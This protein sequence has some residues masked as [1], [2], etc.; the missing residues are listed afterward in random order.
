MGEKMIL[1]SIT[2][3][4]VIQ[5]DPRDMPAR[6][7]PPNAPERDAIHPKP[8]Y[9]RR[10]RHPN[11]VSGGIRASHVAK[12]GFRVA[13]ANRSRPTF[14]SLCRISA[15][16]TE[17]ERIE[18]VQK[19]RLVEWSEE[20]RQRSEEKRQRSEENRQL[21]ETAQN[22]IRT[23]WPGEER[24]RMEASF[25]GQN[26]KR[27]VA[28]WQRLAARCRQEDVFRQFILETTRLHATIHRERRRAT[29]YAPPNDN[30]DG[31]PVSDAVPNLLTTTATGELRDIYPR[32]SQRESHLPAGQ[33]GLLP[34]GQWGFY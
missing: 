26:R 13:L 16:Q 6:R 11:L 19:R 10:L 34:A 32:I 24:Q 14:G 2:H 1:N 25:A 27:I 18:A 4:I 28:N 21:I 29:A 22:T 12:A 20:S 8:P 7:Q 9:A 31:V 3:V 23:G 5:T 30:V 17:C 33:W 15:A